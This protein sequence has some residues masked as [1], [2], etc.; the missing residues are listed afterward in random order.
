MIV[1]RL[2]WKAVCVGEK[3]IKNVHA[4]KVGH[5]KTI[6]CSAA[7]LNMF[8]WLGMRQPFC[9]VDR[10]MRPFPTPYLDEHG[11]FIGDYDSL[12]IAIGKVIESSVG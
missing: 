8:V 2:P 1:T 12:G 11:S 6:D 5:M 7:I 9:L 3:F 4:G 10:D